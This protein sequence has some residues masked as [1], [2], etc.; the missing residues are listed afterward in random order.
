MRSGERWGV[1]W[2]AWIAQGSSVFIGASEGCGA[3]RWSTWARRLRRASELGEGVALFC[4]SW[5]CVWRRQR[6]RATSGLVASLPCLPRRSREQVVVS[7]G[8]GHGSG[9]GRVWR[10]RGGKQVL[11]SFTGGPGR[12]RGGGAARGQCTSTACTRATRAAS[13]RVLG[14]RPPALVVVELDS[15]VARVV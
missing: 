9:L 4:G 13:G 8:G 14:A 12:A 5:R 10:R 11:N 1:R 2:C 15:G 3:V 7:G 6:G